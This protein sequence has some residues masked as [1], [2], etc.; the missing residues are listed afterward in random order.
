MRGPHRARGLAVLLPALLAGCAGAPAV[1]PVLSLDAQR[2]GARPDLAAAQ[3]VPLDAGQPV[4]L[5]LD[6]HAACLESRGGKSSYVA[7]RLPES[8]QPYLL[9][10]TSA[11]MGETLFSPRLMLLDGEGRT[12]REVPRDD[13]MFRGQTLSARLRAAP[14]ERYL[15]IA[16]DPPSIGQQVAQITGDSGM[17]PVP[18]GIGA[19]AMIHTGSEKQQRFTYAHNGSVT[20][21]AQPMPKAN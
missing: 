18:V 19:V 9:T 15:I 4:K 12:L 20:I 3:I 5:D 16:S 14:A 21:S 11:P 13:F 10:V 6:G 17:I 7:L 8:A 1:P 2:C